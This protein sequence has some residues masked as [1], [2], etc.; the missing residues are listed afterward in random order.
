MADNE[1]EVTLKD[2]MAMLKTIHTKV[3]S[4]RAI[5][6]T[7]PPPARR[8][9]VSPSD[10][11]VRPCAP[12]CGSWGSDAVIERVMFSREKIEARVCERAAQ[13]SKDFAGATEDSFVVVGLLAGCY[14]FMADS[15]RKL[16]IPHQVDLSQ[17]R[18]MVSAPPVQPMSRSRKTS[19]RLLRARTCCYWTRCATRGGRWSA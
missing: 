3:D 19:I 17:R 18:P 13:V 2:V 11:D 14:M 6:R 10:S 15:T 16:T 8:L 4:G 5:S 7:P 1:A 9:K 12:L